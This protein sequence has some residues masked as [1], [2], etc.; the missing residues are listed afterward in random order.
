MV[1]LIKQLYAKY[2]RVVY[3]NWKQVMNIIK[4]IGFIPIKGYI[5]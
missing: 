2:V 1:Q 3:L 4:W 5:K